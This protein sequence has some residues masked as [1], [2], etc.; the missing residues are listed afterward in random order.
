MYNPQTTVTWQS[1]SQGSTT[2]K[3]GVIVRFIPPFQQ[4]I[5]LDPW[6]AELRPSQLKFNPE[7]SSKNERYLV[8]II[9][10]NRVGTKDVY[11]APRANALEPVD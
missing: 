8:K 3:T 11:Y 1:S 2:E 4:P 5:K 7:E 9:V 10:S 6:L